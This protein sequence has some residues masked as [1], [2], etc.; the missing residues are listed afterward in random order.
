MRHLATL[1]LSLALLVALSGAGEASW[2]IDIEKLAF[3][4][5]GEFSCVEC[6]DDVGMGKPHPDPAAVNRR[7]AASF[8]AARCLECHDDVEDDVSDGRH[9]S[10]EA[11]RPGEFESCL[12]CHYPHYPDRYTPRAVERMVASGMQ[13]PEQPVSIG[14]AQ[15]EAPSEANEDDEPCLA[16]HRLGRSD[17]L[18]DKKRLE[19]LCLHCHG[20]TE[21][22]PEAG[23]LSPALDADGLASTTHA[24]LSCLECHREA[25]AYSHGEQGRLACSSCHQPHRASVADDVHL[26]VDCEA[27]HLRDV[28]LA[29]DTRTGRVTARYD[30][31][32]HHNSAVH[33]MAMAKEDGECARCHSAEN[34]IGAAATI[35]PAKGVLC[36]PCHTATL[37]VADPISI[38]SLILFFAGSLLV[39]SVWFSGGTKIG[40]VV[41]SMLRSLFSSRI[42]LVLKALVLDVLLNR[43]LFGQS[44]GR[45]LIHS[46]IFVPFIIRFLWGVAALVASN[47][48]P[49]WSLTWILVD[50]H[51]PVTAFAFDLTGVAVILGV[52][53]AVLRKWSRHSQEL[54]GLPKQ[55]LPALALIG[56]VVAVGFAL[57][58]MGIAMAHRPAG[59]GFAFAGYL[60]SGLFS[61]SQGLNTAYSYVWYAHALLTGAF[62]A[63]LPFSRMLHI[64]T[65]PL[66]MMV[67]AARGDH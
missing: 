13:P 57:E 58:A 40:G 28:E 6:H 24:S 39:L 5:H 31:K 42:L 3:S 1:I 46:L 20:K 55:D 10:L 12:E 30:R 21:S 60:L 45:W 63:Y 29:R 4:S 54:P 14:I 48:A 61:G 49:E 33:D 62:V 18:E 37:S 43:K 9:G 19:S 41:G 2:L 25:A 17:G 16:C 53:L 32:D 11:A 23:P 34:T 67:N 44:R 27:C 36:M 56:G 50:R 52:C 15:P 7:P 8:S 26:T 66:V 38:V 22:R 47:Y 59:G 35:L 65:A 64:L 51:H